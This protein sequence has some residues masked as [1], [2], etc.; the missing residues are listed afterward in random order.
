M[1]VMRKEAGKGEITIKI[2]E[3]KCFLSENN[4]R[5]PKEMNLASHLCKLQYALCTLP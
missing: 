4:S 1:M 5:V 2:K 3:F